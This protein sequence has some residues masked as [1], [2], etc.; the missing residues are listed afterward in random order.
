ME[1]LIISLFVSH[2]I[3]F[4]QN[5]L[6][7][8]EYTFLTIREL[9][10]MPYKRIWVLQVAVVFGGM[11]TMMFDS[12]AAMLYILVFFKICVDVYLHMKEHRVDRRVKVK[13]PDAV[14]S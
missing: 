13:Q 8:K 7:N 10:V 2:G 9:M 1:E 11:L 12:P 14:G 5:Y 3:S 4:V 6:M